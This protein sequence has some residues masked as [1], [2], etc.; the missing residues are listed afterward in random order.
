[1]LD[2]GLAIPAIQEQG[3]G[4]PLPRMGGLTMTEHDR[5]KG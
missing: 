4:R 1:M 3:S 5:D 2:I